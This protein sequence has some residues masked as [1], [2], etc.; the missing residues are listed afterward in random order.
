MYCTWYTLQ[1]TWLSTAVRIIVILLYCIRISELTLQKT[2]F[3]LQYCRPVQ[4]TVYCNLAAKWE[5]KLCSCSCSCEQKHKDP[6]E[7]LET[8]LFTWTPELGSTPGIRTCMGYE[9]VVSQLDHVPGTQKF[10]NRDRSGSGPQV[11]DQGSRQIFLTSSP[12]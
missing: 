2:T 1:K 10:S 8:G 4:C 12:D 9:P 11:R 6:D 7:G 3:P 5:G